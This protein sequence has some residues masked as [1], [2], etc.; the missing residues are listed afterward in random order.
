MK[1]AEGCLVHRGQCGL[2]Q[3]R[4]LEPNKAALERQ[5]AL[6]NRRPEDALRVDDACVRQRLEPR[7]GRSRGEEH[8]IARVVGHKPE[9][10]AVSVAR[11]SGI[12][13]GS[14]ALTSSP[15]R[16]SARPTSRA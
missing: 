8:G 1:L 14:P 11:L 6:T 7:D 5:D 2:R 15:R 16:T 9:G 12:G 10:S 4:V 3:K 13:N